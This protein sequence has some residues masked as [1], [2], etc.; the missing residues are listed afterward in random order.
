LFAT[1]STIFALLYA[2]FPLSKKKEGKEAH[3]RRDTYR[4]R[5]RRVGEKKNKKSQKVVP[6]KKKR[7]RQE[8]TAGGN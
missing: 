1:A 2:A 4:W 7:R 3:Y 8:F 5:R 6:R